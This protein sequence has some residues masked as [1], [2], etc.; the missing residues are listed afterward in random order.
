MHGRGAGYN[1]APGEV[2]S[3]SMADTR[4]P[5]SSIAIMPCEKEE[6]SMM[7]FEYRYGLKRN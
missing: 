6:V 3:S 7:G 5:P 2:I 1:D 4:L